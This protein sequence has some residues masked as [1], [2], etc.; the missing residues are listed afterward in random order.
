MCIPDFPL[1]FKVFL[2]TNQDIAF[3]FKRHD[4]LGPKVWGMCKCLRGQDCFKSDLGT[5]PKDG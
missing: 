2:V 4:C 3:V 1:A 5:L